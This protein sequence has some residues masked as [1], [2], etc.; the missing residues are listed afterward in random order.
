MI[1]DKKLGLKIAESTE[2]AFWADLKSKIEKDID[3]NMKNIVINKHIL[4]LAEDKL[5][6]PNIKKKLPSGVG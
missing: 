4:A 3:M 1:E 6:D 2:E 5:R